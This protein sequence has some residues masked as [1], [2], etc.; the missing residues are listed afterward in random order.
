MM[1]SKRIHVLA[2]VGFG[3]ILG[4]VPIAH[5][6]GTAEWAGNAW[7]Y[8][9]VKS[10]LSR[11]DRLGR[12]DTKTNTVTFSGSNIT[13][14]MT[15]FQPGYRDMTFEQHDLTNPT[16][17]V[18]EGATIQWN[19]VNMDIGSGMEHGIIITRKSPPYAALPLRQT[20]PGTARIMPLLPWRSTENLKQA[21]YAEKGITFRTPPSGV[22]WYYCPAPGHAAMGMYGKFIVK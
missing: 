18:P 19:L 1:S 15:A 6:Q 13:I 10:Y 3:L 16:I 9:R 22:Y 7:S 21:K 11:S 2:A 17:V 5:A 8:A 20:G 4:M 14:D 12:A